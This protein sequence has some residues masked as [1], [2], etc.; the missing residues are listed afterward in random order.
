MG[1]GR[2]SGGIR[3]RLALGGLLLMVAHSASA[4]IQNILEAIQS[5]E[6]RFARTGSEVPFPPLGWMQ[7]RFYPNSRFENEGGGL[8]QAEVEQNTFN[9]GGMLPPYVGPRDM[10]L[11]GGDAAWDYIA[12]KSG[13]YRD[14]SVLRLIPVAGWL[15]QFGDA[16]LAGA[17]AAPIFSNEL[18]GDGPWSCNGYSGVI[19]MHWLSDQLQLLYGGVYQYSF[20]QHSGYPYL[21]VLW[22]PTP[23]CS[24]N[25]V[26]PWPTFTYVPA[27]RWLLQL[28]VSPGGSSW[29]QNGG[30]YE[31]SES[32]NS[33]NLTAGAGYRLYE[34][35]WLFA[36]AGVAGLRGF[37]I[38][39][40][41]GTTRF[42]SQPSPMFTLAL[43]FRP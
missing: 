9:L 28:G 6:F 37:E 21:G 3:R 2:C 4:G 24:L 26:F 41:E 42:E 19:G 30:N 35:L 17:F 16:D 29:V 20:G 38:E 12:V 43:Q 11:L 36:G 39:S 14:Q 10:L 25:L 31:V 32:L 7:N 40:Q 5:S 23:R 34:K 15:H 1:R 22:N 18:L 13:P 33:W 27:D 8:P